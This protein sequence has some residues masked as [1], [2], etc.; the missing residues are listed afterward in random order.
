L[1]HTP[2]VIFL[3]SSSF[4]AGFLFSLSCLAD[5]V[6]KH[7]LIVGRVLPQRSMPPHLN[8]CYTTTLAHD[9][10]PTKPRRPAI[11][12]ISREPYSFSRDWHDHRELCMARHNPRTTTS[13]RRTVRKREENGPGSTST[14]RAIEK[15]RRGEENGSGSHPLIA[16]SRRSEEEKRTDLDRIH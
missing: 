12:L 10:R 16:R 1:G 11:V 8:S 4:S 13:T 9:A 3:F 7:G 15:K 14:D 2:V 5:G 6:G